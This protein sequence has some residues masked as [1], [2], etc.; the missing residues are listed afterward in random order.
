MTGFYFGNKDIDSKP[1]ENIHDE[2]ILTSIANPIPQKKSNKENSTKLLQSALNQ[3]GNIS[4]EES[5]KPNSTYLPEHKVG[6]AIC[7]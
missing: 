5:A 4:L 6:C 7:F 1:K 2:T 3:H